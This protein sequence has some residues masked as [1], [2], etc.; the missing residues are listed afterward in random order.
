MNNHITDL[1]GQVFG[2]LTAKEFVRSE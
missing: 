2:R 1:A